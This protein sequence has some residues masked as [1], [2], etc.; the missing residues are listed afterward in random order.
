MTDRELAR[1]AEEAL[2]ARGFTKIRT[3]TSFY[4]EGAEVTARS[5]EGRKCVFRAFAEKKR[6]REGIRLVPSGPND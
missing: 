3:D 6:G 5:P 2:A 4:L 1:R